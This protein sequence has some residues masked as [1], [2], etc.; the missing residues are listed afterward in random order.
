[1]AL[2]QTPRLF[3][4]TGEGAPSKSEGVGGAFWRGSRETFPSWV[5]AKPMIFSFAFE[6]GGAVFAPLLF[7][8]QSTS[9]RI[10]V[11]RVIPNGFGFPRLM[12]Y[13]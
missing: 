10:L 6:L 4:P 2:K 1:M 11:Y 12:C 7:A 5:W 8:S 13:S 3:L 9:R